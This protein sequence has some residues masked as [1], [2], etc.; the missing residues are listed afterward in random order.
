[1]WYQPDYAHRLNIKDLDN[2]FFEMGSTAPPNEWRDSSLIIRATRNCPWNRCQF[3]NLYKGKKFE[4]R[5]VAELK[6][7]IDAARLLLDEVKAA[8]LKFG[9]NGEE[10]NA[11]IRRQ[12]KEAIIQGNP[13]IY[14]RDFADPGLLRLRMGN[15]EC[16]VDWLGSGCKTA[17]LQDSNSLIMRT[18]ELIEAIRYLK[19]TFPTILRITSYARAKTCFEK[20]LAEL[21]EL[22]DAGLSRLHVGL[23]SGC[24]E[25]LTEMQKGVTAE[26]HSIGIRKA[27]EAGISISEYVMPGLGG[28]K[29]SNIHALETARVLNEMNADFIRI[30]SL[31]ISKNLPLFERCQTGEF[32][33]L[34][35]DEVVDE[36][37]QLIQNLNCRSY[38]LSDYISNLLFGVEGQLPQDKEKMLKIIE[39]YKARSPM[40]KLEFRLRQR[41]AIYRRMYGEKL[42]PKLDGL[43]EEAM[44]S[45]QKEAPDAKAKVN[46]AVSSLKQ[47]FI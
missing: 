41:L 2:C 34:S 33:E 16:I 43:V 22:H 20:P 1:M 39:K 17:F 31:I 28:K 38:V 45:I 32:E 44:E 15:L 6:K 40:E 12:I 47:K 36:I 42:M 18:P 9:F 27:M 30:R 21:K 26:E 4:Y 19:E 46:R 3:C 29:W 5:K 37:G 10:E 25:V 8:S 35:E 23:E 14:W 24:D 7:D 13:E 11:R